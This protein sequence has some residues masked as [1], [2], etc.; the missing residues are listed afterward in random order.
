[1]PKIPKRYSRN[2]PQY[3]FIA[4]NFL[5][6]STGMK[7]AKTV[8]V[9]VPKRVRFDQKLLTNYRDR[10][11]MDYKIFRA[12]A[13]K[14]DTRFV[15]RPLAAKTIQRAFRRRLAYKRTPS[16]LFKEF[17]KVWPKEKL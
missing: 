5:T 15:S 7:P 6:A 1:M 8:K 10:S 4:N 2:G 9:A 13:N 11:H 3:D 17:R 12:R 14:G 16:Y